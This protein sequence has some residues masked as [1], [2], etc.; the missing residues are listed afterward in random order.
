MPKVLRPVFPPGFSSVAND[1]QGRYI[2]QVENRA[3]VRS[4]SS[5]LPE[6]VEKVTSLKGKALNGLVV[7]I[8]NA[9]ALDDVRDMPG[10]SWLRVEQ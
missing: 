6:S 1:G 9:N 2:V 7:R 10:S 8:D 5:A 4:I 3:G